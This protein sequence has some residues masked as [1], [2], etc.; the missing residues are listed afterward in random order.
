M[1]GVGSFAFAVGG[2]EGCAGLSRV[3]GNSEDRG[4][5]SALLHQDNERS[6]GLRRVG[7]RV[8]NGVACVKEDWCTQENDDLSAGSLKAEQS[9]SV[10]F[11]LAFGYDRR[12][13]LV[14]KAARTTQ[15][16]DSIHTLWMFGNGL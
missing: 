1:R 4:R 2:K 3:E 6:G 14:Y 9:W 16:F 8:V 10:D 11:A 13:R 5:L 12:R 7:R 15:F